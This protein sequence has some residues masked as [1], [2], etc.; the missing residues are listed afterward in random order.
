MIPALVAHPTTD[1][2][3]HISYFASVVIAVTPIAAALWA[4]YRHHEKKK[5]ERLQDHTAKVEALH[6][7][8]V[9]REPTLEDPHPKLGIFQRL[10]HMESSLEALATGLE[11]VR[12]EVTPNGGNTDRL[13]DRVKRLEESLTGRGE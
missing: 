11:D 3:A 13:G 2:L 4:A 5:A 6:D 8:I 7:V 9:G 12:R 1:P 10:E